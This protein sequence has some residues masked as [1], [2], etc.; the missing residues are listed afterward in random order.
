MQEFEFKYAPKWEIS[1]QSIR[2]LD[3]KRS[4]MNRNITL[5]WFQSCGDPFIYLSK[6]TL[7]KTKSYLESIK[8]S[9]N[10]INKKNLNLF[11]R[12]VLQ[13]I[14]ANVQSMETYYDFTHNIE[15]D[16]SIGKALE[17]MFG[18]C[19]YTSILNSVT[20]KNYPHKLIHEYSEMMLDMSIVRLD[21]A[22]VSTSNREIFKKIR[23]EIEENLETKKQ[24]A[25]DFYKE[26]GVLKQ[27][28]DFFIEVD[29]SRGAFSWWDDSNRIVAVDPGRFIYFRDSTNSYKLYDAAIYP[30]VIHELGHGL[31]SIMSKQT[32]PEGLA[33]S[34][35]H[36][37][38][39]VHGINSEGVAMELEKNWLR[40]AK[41]NLSKYNLSTEDFNRINLKSKTYVANK[42]MQ[43]AKEVFE[44]EFFKLYNSEKSVSSY[45]KNEGRRKISELTK[46]KQ[47][48]SDW[49]LLGDQENSETFQHLTYFF[50][51]KRTNKLMKK[52]K[53]EK[54]P[55]DK[56]LS[57]LLTGAWCDPKAQEQFIFELYLPRIS[58]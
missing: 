38:C 54:I 47:F 18:K 58:K 6:Y 43:L 40:V 7:E 3:K 39:Q 31:N 52:L 46:I 5:S 35:I 51:E 8:R 19:A 13:D 30:I 36:Y 21:P 50:G 24:D 37:I 22:I 17:G 48:C 42:M 45:A 55:E 28:G 33:P 4:D 14:N 49:Y 9:S 15:K 34:M 1:S 44:I 27:E 32:M 10:R 16:V 20:P 56:A 41:D 26:K 2:N 11:D 53:Q 12:L 25:I 29:W 23:Q 57:A